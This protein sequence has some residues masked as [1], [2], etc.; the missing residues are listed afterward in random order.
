MTT[1][2]GPVSA[3]SSA[4]APHRLARWRDP[5]LTFL[6]LAVAL[7]SRW[8]F[9]MRFP[10]AWDSMLYLRAL[11]HFNATIH[12]PQPPGYLFYVSAARLARLIV[13]NANHA[14][15]WVSVGASAFAI[16]ALYLLGR[17]LFDWT[18]GAIAAAL[19]LTSVTFWYYSEIAYPYTTLAAGS[20]A[21]ALLARAVQV[22]LLPGIPGAA[23]AAFAFGLV[24]GFRQDLLLFL[25]PLFLLAF[26]RRPL[27]HWFAALGAGG[28]GVL[29]WLLP[30]AA[31]SE[32]LGKY[33]GATL[34]QGGNAGAGSSPFTRGLPAFTANATELVTF[35]WRGLY[36]AVA[37]L[38]YLA[39]RRF[40]PRYVK[41]GAVPWV[42]LWLAPPLAVYLFGHIGDYGYTF[43]LLPA[44]LL[45]A[46]R[47]IV[48]AA[49]DAWAVAGAVATRI[50]LRW[51]WRPAVSQRTASIALA[52]VV[53][54]GVAGANG[55]LFT[56][57]WTQLSAQ[58]IKCFDRAMAARLNYTRRFPASETIVFSAGYY[59]HVR[60][61][62]PRYQAWL[63]DPPQG[64]QVRKVIPPG[65]RYLV[66]FDEVAR[67][68]SGANLQYY[69]LPCTGRPL[70]YATV[71]SGDTLSYDNANTTFR[72]R[73]RAP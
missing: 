9:R 41:N 5:L 25:A 60:Y 21:L 19:L 26:L 1:V 28:L 73:R 8:P 30:T 61:Y 11:D 63:Y 23:L 3:A 39:L 27:T 48:L 56:R 59:E 31:L 38:A 36:V 64:Q 10:Y 6:F 68:A 47:G 32:G 53:G 72:L 49:T 55:Y 35:L 4:G 62:L 67:P 17:L 2:D 44:L 70:Y 45:L 52:L 37:P 54:L 51:R 12:Q 14:L 33:L 43:S 42:V 50:G 15:V 22:G 58:G 40:L 18:T 20:V 16:A 69:T 7:V 71:Q 24:G 13:P 65:T 46:A 66:I 57:R 29:L 34:L